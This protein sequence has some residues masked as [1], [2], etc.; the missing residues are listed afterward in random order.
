MFD[1][2]KS[3]V[4]S[5]RGRSFSTNEPSMTRTTSSNYCHKH[6]DLLRVY[7]ETCNKVICRDCTISTEHKTHDYKLIDECYPKHHQQIETNVDL[8]KH[9]MDAINTM[10]TLLDMHEREVIEQGEEIQEQINT[11]AQHMINQV[12]RSCQ[13]LSQQLHNIVIQKKQLLAAQKQ[14]AQ[15]LHTQ[16]NTCQEMIR[17]SLKEWTKQ[18]ILTEKHTMIDQINTTTEHVD[19]TVFQPIENANMKFT[20]TDSTERGIGFISSTTYEKATLEFRPCSVNHSTTAT[21]AL[22]SQDGLPFPLS[23][24]NCTLSSPGNTH[25]V[26]CDIT[27]THQEGKYNITFTPSTRHDRLIVQVGGVDIPDSP[28]TLPVIPTPEMR[29]KPVNTI[30]G[31]NSPWGISVCDNGDIVVAENGAHC[32]TKLKKG[33]GNV[34]FTNEGNFSIA[35][36]CGVA[37]ANDGHILVTEDHRLQK[38]TASGVCVKSIGS[39]ESGN[40]QLQFHTPRGI[41]VH[42]T[43]GQIFVADSYNNRIQ[44]FNNDLMFLQTISITRKPF[45]LPRDVAL[46]TKGYLYVAEY[47]NH[48]ITKL[49]CITSKGKNMYSYVKRFGS[50][51]C[52]PGQLSHPSSL[53][54]NDNLVYICERGNDRISIFN[55]NGKFLNCYGYDYLLAPNGL[56]IDTFGNLY[57]SDTSNNRI[58]VY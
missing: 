24:I 38:V 15:I 22:H 10:V 14:Q 9:K 39:N 52:G 35:Y 6:N 44:I 5:E 43:T 26:K 17:Y 36:P 50:N 11:H 7:C 49:Q 30:T 20:K 46:D 48:C 2:R 58:V 40:G 53:A 55:T 16:L 18:Q 34:Q 28:F 45:N 19:P 4:N 37:V 41:T 33:R 23:L 31:L 13:Q 1:L 42:P 51:G 47:D 27:P 56:T 25:S 32:I 29:G 21:I 57:V 54:I 3:F 12:Q 8:V